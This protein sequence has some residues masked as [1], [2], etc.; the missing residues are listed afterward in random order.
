MY[1]L[2]FLRLRG[3]ILGE[4]WHI[5]VRFHHRDLE[6]N[7]HGSVDTQVVNIAK[8]ML[9]YPVAYTILL[10][11][12]AVCRFAEW[13]GH[14]VPFGATVFSDSIFLLSG[15]V[16]VIL[17]LTTRRVLPMNTVL[18]KRMSALFSSFR[19]KSFVS[20]GNYPL[21]SYVTTTH[22]G[23]PVLYDGNPN[24]G[25]PGGYSRPLP[26][27]PVSGQPTCTP[28]SSPLSTP[29]TFDLVPRRFSGRDKEADITSA[30]H[31][32]EHGQSRMPSDPPPLMVFIPESALKGT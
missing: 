12:I 22:A 2:V 18:P 11:P 27:P 14:E 3:D 17:F 13:S 6:G 31:R 9:L 4:G 29:E 19:S 7:I 8:G 16:D 28:C 32:A 21:A 23:K 15:L 10:L 20:K 30:L 24:D 25:P 5:K 26:F 1:S